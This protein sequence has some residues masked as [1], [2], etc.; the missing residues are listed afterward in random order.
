MLIFPLEGQINHT[1]NFN[2]MFAS[3]GNTVNIPTSPTLVATTLPNSIALRVPSDN[4]APSVS[5]PQLDNNAS[6]NR[7]SLPKTE[8]PLS[9]VNANSAIE[10]F[11]I[12]S[13]PANS[14]SYTA[15]AQTSFLAQLAGGDISPEVRGI[16]VQYDKL[17]SFA[18]VKYKPSNAGKPVDPIGIFKTLLQLEHESEDNTQPIDLADVQNESVAT[19]PTDNAIQASAEPVYAPVETVNTQPQETSQSKEFVS[20]QILAYKTAIDNTS[21]TAPTNVELA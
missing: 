14:A 11:S 5:R 19:I 20:P 1:N 12:S 15:N 8:A 4:I 9:F 17:V 7:N 13:L 3:I 6:G 21:D 18:N 10:N 2:N 16:F